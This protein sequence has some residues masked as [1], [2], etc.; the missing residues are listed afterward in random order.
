MFRD[1]NPIK[2]ASKQI[3]CVFMDGGLGDHLGGSFVAAKYIMERYPWV[4]MRVY[5]P[6]FLIEIG[7]LVLPN[8]KAIHGFSELNRYYDERKF[9]IHTKWDGRHSPMKSH[10]VDYAFRMLCDEN[11]SDEHKNS[12]KLDLTD[13]ENLVTVPKYVVFAVGYTVKVRE[14]APATVNVLVDYVKSKGYEAVFLGQEKTATGI[15]HVIQ[16]NFSKEI[17]YSKGINL[18][19]NTS[20][21]EATKIMQGAQAVVGVDC[22]LMHL[23]GYTDVAIVGGYTTVDPIYRMPYRN[24]QLGWN[25]Y[26]VVPPKSLGCRF[27]QSNTNFM[28]DHDYKECLYRDYKCVSTL[29]PNMFIEQLEKVL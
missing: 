18:V 21:L 12:P 24:N 3:Q 15:A 13:V 26:T 7:E 2:P 8:A 17:D 6:D 22:G 20:L 9:T 4:K 16:G 14:F 1:E 10:I 29:T 27:C 23:A 25:C 11:V 5:V 19:N 28:F